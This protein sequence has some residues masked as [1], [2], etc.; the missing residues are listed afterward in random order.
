MTLQEDDTAALASDSETV[1][2]N[3]TA[4]E[5][6]LAGPSA[7][8]PVEG[9]GS[10]NLSLA[11]VHSVYHT[12]TTAYN[13]HMLTLSILWS[14]PRWKRPVQPVGPSA[15][16]HCVSNRFR[17]SMVACAG[18]MLICTLAL[19]CH[20]SNNSPKGHVRS[21]VAQVPTVAQLPTAQN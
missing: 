7:A 17:D 2:A 9:F 13:V 6:A 1:Q 18:T 5:S 4:M 3:I 16:L 19:S 12:P 15:W 21:F 8:H 20:S 11:K 14:L 10:G